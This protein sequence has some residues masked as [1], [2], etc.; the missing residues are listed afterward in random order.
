MGESE[1]CLQGHLASSVQGH[2]TLLLPPDK[3]I[4]TFTKDHSMHGTT[5]WD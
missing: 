2:S 1:C 5:A 4:P 3:A